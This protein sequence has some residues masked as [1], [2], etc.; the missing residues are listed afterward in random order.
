MHREDALVAQEKV[1]TWKDVENC[2]D[3]L[4]FARF[5]MEA[6]AMEA[7]ETEGEWKWAWAICAR[8]PGLTEL[9]RNMCRSA[10]DT[11]VAAGQGSRLALGECQRLFRHR[12]WNCS[13]DTDLLAHSSALRLG[14]REAAF[15]TGIESAGMAYAIT[16]AC[17]RGN[18]PKCRC[19]TTRL[20]YHHR[21]KLPLFRTRLIRR[22]DV[23]CK[24][25][26]NPR[27]RR[28]PIPAAWVWGGCSPDLSYGL[29]FS[30]R[31]LDQREWE[32]DPRALMNLHN[33]K[34]GRKALKQSLQRECKCHGVSGSCTMKTCWKTLPPFAQVSLLSPLPRVQKA[35]M[36]LSSDR[37][38]VFPEEKEKFFSPHSNVTLLPGAYLPS[39]SAG[40]DTLIAFV[41]GSPLRGKRIDRG[42]ADEEV[43][44]GTSG[45]PDAD[46]GRERERRKN[47]AATEKAN[48]SRVRVDAEIV[49]VPVPTD[50][51]SAKGFRSRLSP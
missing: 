14:S 9:Q 33:S 17:A 19:D 23:R 7:V 3:C 34:A 37:K 21:G 6:M 18:L 39:G 35:F 28:H 42:G 32:S 45:D 15:A 51:A 16:Q 27:S 30:R 41:Y 24:N 25:Q 12:R 2:N 13:L 11:M 50:Q 48:G 4:P 36:L 8:I 26:E 40:V 29:G 44:E 1:K 31:F 5:W 49:S 43:H 47:E 20:H 22:I 10:P 46:P 38:R